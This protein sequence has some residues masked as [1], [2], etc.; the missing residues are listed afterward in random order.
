MQ[1]KKNKQK[2]I[3][4]K[5]A[6]KISGYASDYIGY[7][8]RTG[9]IYGEK[10]YSG[11]AWK[12]SQEGLLDYLSRKK[13]KSNQQKRWEAL[14]GGKE[15]IS[16]KEAAK[17]S[18]YAPDYIGQLVRK[19]KIEGEKKLCNVSWQ[20]TPEAIKLYRKENS[21]VQ[22]RAVPE[23]LNYLKLIHVIPQ[24]GNR[25]WGFSWR[26]SLAAF[27]IFFLVSGLAPIKFLRSSLI[28]AVTGGEIKTAQFY[29]TIVTGDWQNSQNVK[30]LP[31]VSESGNINS[32]SEANSAMYKKGPLSLFCQNFEQ[33][34]IQQPAPEEQ[35]IEE[36]ELT[37]PSQETT[38]TGTTTVP[39]IIEEEATSTFPEVT[40]D[41][42][43][44]TEATSTE[45]TSTP[46]VQEEETISTESTST[47][48]TT[49]EPT[50]FFEKAK[51]F[52]GFKAYAQESDFSAKI[53]L[54]FAIGEKEPDILPIEQPATTSEFEP[55][56]FWTPPSLHPVKD[57]FDSLVN[58]AIFIAKAE[59]NNPPI[60]ISTTTEDEEDEAVEDI[61]M[62]EV[63][64]T[65]TTE[66]T[67][68]ATTTDI[69]TT[70]EEEATTTETTITEATT[71]E[72]TATPEIT[73]TTETLPNLDTKII[74]WWSFDGENWQILDTISDYPLSNFLNGGY[75]SY[76]VSFLKNFED[77]GNLKI[78]FEGV[79]GGETNV[80]V[81]LD[82]VWVEVVYQEYSEEEEEEFE[83][84]TIKED[85]RADEE[86]EFEVVSKKE[87]INENIVEKLVA[88]V[89][90]VFEEKPKVKA[91]LLRPDNKELLLQEGEDFSAETHSPTKIKIFKPEGFRP[92]LHKLKIDFEKNGKVY[93][94][95]KDFTW[96]VLAINTNKSIYLP[97]NQAHIQMAVL[98]N[99]GHTICDADLVLEIIAPDGT[100][101]TFATPGQNYPVIEQ[102]Q[103][104][105]EEETSA[106]DAEDVSTEQATTTEIITTS[107]EATSTEAE[108][109][110]PTLETES[111]TT[112]E[113]TS[114]NEVATTTSFLDK[115][116]NSFSVSNVRAATNNNNSSVGLIEKSGECGPNT[117]TYTPDYS[118]YYNIAGAGTY[119]IKLTAT[120]KNGTREITDSFEV[121]ESAPFDI[122][123]IGPTRIY[124]PATYEMIMKIKVNQDF[125][126]QVVEQVP[127]TF[128][129]TQV[130]NWKLIYKTATKLIIWDVDWKAGEIHELKYTFDAPDISPYLYL[131]GPI[132][133]GDFQEIRQ[134]QIAS[135]VTIDSEDW[136]AFSDGDTTLDGSFWSNVTGDDCDMQA[137]SG[138]TPSSDTGPSVDH[139]YGDST[140]KYL[141]L[142]TSSG[143]CQGDGLYAGLESDDIDADTYSVEIDFWYHM[144]G[145]T[146]GTSTLDVYYDT[147]WDNDIWYQEYLDED[148]WKNATTSLDAY[149]GTIKLR[150]RS[151]SAG[152]YYGDIAYDDIVITGTLRNEAPNTPTLDET[153]AFPNMLASTTTPVLGGFSATDPDTDDVEFWVEWDTDANFGSP[154]TNTTATTTSGATTTYAI[155]SPLSEDTVYWW[156]VKARDPGGSNEWSSYSV[157]RSITASTSIS[158]DQWFQTTGDQFDTD[159][160]TDTATTATSVKIGGW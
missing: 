44:V 142:E 14:A 37:L 7:L 108:E 63:I 89:S 75:F 70:T 60:A 83:L 24:A 47:E 28:T 133:I 58:K 48:A 71:T 140:H 102:Q 57:F 101:T 156:R 77:V 106:P 4:L 50:S 119:Q 52:F 143:Y 6:G 87:K 54:S 2:F 104:I 74:I 151:I 1:F 42:T 80:T 49:S 67:T 46:P 148:V 69:T 78:K 61:V 19:G 56:S 3:S 59:G 41:E 152:N 88:E 65:T 129:T 30:G 38:T 34:E 138:G 159:T 18:G 23:F 66:A 131:L 73:A 96:G 64:E 146:I 39:E 135:D 76:D 134:W 111:T 82:S 11:N 144:Y 35:K 25:A 154:A 45:V 114:T 141:Y 145:S 13:S 36:Q 112:E 29:P 117:V 132:Q 115:I 98:D 158:Y 85:W 123:R 100:K 9:K 113:T 15:Y 86:P 55:T 124:P 118:T 122:E 32:F 103:E 27:V 160:L 22:K 16:L 92:G 94:L 109:E 130:A 90:S 121:R 72:T 155:T 91:T 21:K 136:E 81:Y 51:R 40:T 126:G 79:V 110:T 149:T 127:D 17:I 53:K 95:E 5:E 120:T 137:D 26:L 128:K 20:T 99:E 139:T 31:E 12:V 84:K 97:G 68:T 150:F 125:Y 107:T 153:P 10:V 116:K 8:I 93:N 105:I 33:P 62:Q 147:S 43:T 157:K